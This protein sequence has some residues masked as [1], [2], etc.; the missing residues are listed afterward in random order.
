MREE[1]KKQTTYSSRRIAQIAADVLQRTSHLV[2][3]SLPR[4][5]KREIP[6]T[7][8]RDQILILLFSNNHQGLHLAF[9]MLLKCRGQ[10]LNS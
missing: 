9:V 1:Q 2:L 7:G 10:A 8:L 4:L 3:L 5:S 6:V